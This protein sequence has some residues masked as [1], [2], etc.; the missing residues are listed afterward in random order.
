VTDPSVIPHEAG[1]S[2][3]L[4]L[5]QR[6]RAR[7]QEAW[8]RLLR[9]YAPLVELWAQR[10]GLQEADAADVRQEVFLAV[11]HA[12]GQFHCDRPGDTFRGWLRT[13]T[14]NKVIDFCSRRRD[15]A[16]PGDLADREALARV[17]P[18]QVDESA[19]QAVEQENQVLYRRALELMQQDFERSSWQAFWRTVIDGQTPQDVA[20][21]LQ[22]TVNAVYLAKSRVLARLREEFTDAIGS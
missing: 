21:E 19:D 4:S 12:I 15:E 3:S 20:H 17:S 11:S 7:D 13:I 1:H 10:A 22:I 8:E 5:L 14:R 6:V 2:T 18:A 9:L 16:A